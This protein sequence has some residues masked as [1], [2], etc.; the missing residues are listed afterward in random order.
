MGSEMRFEFGANWANFVETALSE[1]KISQSMR[2]LKGFLRLEDLRGK[3]FLDIGSGSG[4]HSLAALR[5]GADRILSFDYDENSVATTKK[6]HEHVGSPLHWTVQQGSILD[7]AYVNRLEK[8][9]V[10]YSWG[11]LH[12]TG[13]MWTAI[14]NAAIPLKRDAVFYTALYSPEIYVSPPSHYWLGVKRAYNSASKLKKR[15]ME[16]NYVWRTVVRPAL[17]AG[18]NP[19]AIMRQYGERGMTFWTDVRDWLGGY[20]MEFAGFRDTVQFCKTK[21]E[22]GLDLVNC[23]AGEGNTEFLFASLSANQQWREIDE[24]RKRIPLSGP[25][26]WGERYLYAAELDNLKDIADSDAFPRRSHLMLYEDGKP[27]GLAH[28]SHEHI[29]TYGL[30]R[31][32]HWDNHLYFSAS[33]STNPNF[34]GRAYTYVAEY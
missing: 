33:D 1:E 14:R 29:R 23:Q 7:E 18:Q 10:V 20:P 12:H 26:H 17:R 31:F 32:C 9:D 15:K 19:L 13:D 4:L 28:S 16:L 22:T 21:I 6:L 11:V 2:H 30:G 8:F 27:L 24:G 34:N 25:Y 5:L 3:S